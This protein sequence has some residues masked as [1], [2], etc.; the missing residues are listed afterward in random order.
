MLVILQEHKRQTPVRNGKENHT[1]KS[2]NRT[3]AKRNYQKKMSQTT[4]INITKRTTGG[5]GGNS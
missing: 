5:K 3:A 1:T 4:S 2:A